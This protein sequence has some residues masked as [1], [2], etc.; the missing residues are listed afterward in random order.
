MDFARLS[1]PVLRLAVAFLV[2]A[3]ALVARPVMAA[4]DFTDLWWN[5][6]E[7]G[8]GVNFVQSDNF[9]FAT[10][11]IYGPANKPTWYTGQLTRDSNGIW[12]GPLYSSTG[13]YFG[14]V[15]NGTQ[16]DID[17]VGNATFIADSDTTGSLSYNVDSVTVS[18]PVERQSLQR[19]DIA[20]NYAGAL[21][22]DVYNCDGGAA[23]TTRQRFVDASAS[24]AVGGAMQL[25]FSFQGG[26][27]CSFAGNATQAGKLYRVNNAT[28]TCGVGPATIA[29]LKSTAQGLEGRW[30]APTLGGCTEFGKFAVVLK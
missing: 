1:R 23:V 14:A 27:T 8:W 30:S 19:I 10:F 2:V 20:G 25:N 4:I 28:Y 12:T 17:Q 21:I 24:L 11:F 7:P 15:F 5:P 22:T 3:G 26:G 16:R 9:I 6:A 29:E 13:S 18:K